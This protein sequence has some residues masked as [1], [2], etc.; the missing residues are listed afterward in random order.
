M[1]DN[2]C[3]YVKYQQ[4]KYFVWKQEVDA[5]PEP[6]DDA[7]SFE[8]RDAAYQHAAERA[9]FETPEYGIAVLKF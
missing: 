1:S 8:T 5:T 4:G 2:A 6:P 7:Q 3:I 9:D